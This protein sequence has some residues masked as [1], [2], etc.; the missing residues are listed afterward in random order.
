MEPMVGEFAAEL[1]TV[2]F[3]K[4]R[5]ASVTGLLDTPWTSPEYWLSQIRLP[6]LFHPMI[7]R[8]EE[9]GVNL[10]LEV[11][12]QAVLAGMAHDCVT[13][14][15]A[16][17]LA[18]HRRD[19]A[20][21]DALAACL[22]GA[23]A[24]GASVDWPALLPGGNRVDLPTYAFERERYW[25]GPPARAANLSAVGLREVAHPLLGAELD[26]AGDGPVVFTGSLSING[27]PW[28]ADHAVAGAVVLPGTALADLVLEAATRTGSDLVEE[29]M[30]EAPLV[31]PRHGPITVQVVVDPPDSSGARPVRVHSR[32]VER[33]R[34][35]LDPAR[36]RLAGRRRRGCR[37]V[38]VG[39]GV[40]PPV[41][42]VVVDVEGGLRAAGG[43]GLRVRCGV[44]GVAGVVASW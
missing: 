17:I 7:A 27:A 29:L 36:V 42:A 39:G 18:L 30:F 43:A 9:Q 3:G 14:E 23:W 38:R 16:S 19:R 34:D 24:A 8:L 31:L 40:W 26:L 6:V 15:D 1:D 41:D 32:P 20:E 10:F 13:G 33:P 25:L 4:P 44:P 12:P 2:T 35:R 37:C 11:G 22:A 21:P 28:L 5:I